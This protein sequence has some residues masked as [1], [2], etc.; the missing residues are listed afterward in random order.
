MAMFDLTGK[1]AFVT[2]SSR[3]IGSGIALALAKQG[4]NVAVNCVTNLEKCDLISNEIKNIGRDSFSTQADVSKKDQ[5][6]NIFN[7]VREKWGRLDILVNNAGVID[8]SDFENITEESWDRVLDINLKGQFLCAQ[9]AVKL[10]KTNNWG[11]II[12][13]ASISSGGVGIGFKSISH[14]T[15]SKGGVVALTE[16][17]AIE[18]AKYGINVNAIA[19]GAIESDMSNAL[20]SDENLIKE[21]LKNIPK[22]RIGKPEDI[23]AAAV[24]LASNEADYITGTV[25]YVDGGWLAG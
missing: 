23:G 7:Q 2:G 1:Y 13:I 24:F 15:A 6:Q 22:G 11:R 14:Y 19:P 16:N 5:V 8:Y 18:L 9:E 12:N 21:T 10:M 25:I 17:M 20:R 4:A 3:G